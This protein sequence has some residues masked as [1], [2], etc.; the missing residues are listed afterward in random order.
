VLCHWVDKQSQHE[1]DDEGIAKPGDE[2][3]LSRLVG[4]PEKIGMGGHFAQ[5]GND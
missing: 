4:T 1:R 5:A 2:L 3:P